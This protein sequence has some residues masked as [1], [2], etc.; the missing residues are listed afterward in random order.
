MFWIQGTE[1]HNF[2]TLSKAKG[3]SSLDLQPIVEQLR[4]AYKKNSG[5]ERFSYTV[6]GRTVVVTPSPG[7]GESVEKV[8]QEAAS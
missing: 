2:K 7:L 3:L 1:T 4:D 5:E 6:A 8:I